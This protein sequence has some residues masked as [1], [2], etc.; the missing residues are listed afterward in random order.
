MRSII[1]LGF[2]EQQASSA[3]VSSQENERRL[4]SRQRSVISKEADLRSSL[5]RCLDFH[6]LRCG[7]EANGDTS[8]ATASFGE[9]PQTS[10]LVAS[11]RSLA[12]HRCLALQPL[13]C[14]TRSVR[15]DVNAR[16]TVHARLQNDTDDSCGADPLLRLEVLSMNKGIR[17]VETNLPWCG[18]P[19]RS[20]V[21]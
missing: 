19:F 12:L 9:I 10:R 5:L 18:E 15:P 2:L 20:H 1:V 7:R 6:M 14:S 4:E 16:A 8:N 3:I 17:D 11:F 13:D 21:Q